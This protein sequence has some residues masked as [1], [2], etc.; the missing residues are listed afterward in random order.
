ME[1]MRSYIVLCEVEYESEDGVEYVHHNHIACGPFK[2][3][4]A[5]GNF[6]VENIKNRDPLKAVLS[7]SCGRNI[8]SLG[9]FQVVE[10]KEWTEVLHGEL[11]EEHRRFTSR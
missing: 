8:S 3:E 5:A 7:K 10:M 11:E 6:M 1:R 4:R 9:D 2:S